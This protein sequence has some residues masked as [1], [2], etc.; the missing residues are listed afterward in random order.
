[1]RIGYDA[2]RYFHN[3]TGLGNYSRTLVNGMMAQYPAHEYSLFDKKAPKHIDLPAQIVSKRNT[4][5]FWRQFGISKDIN[6]K[7]LD[8]YHGLSAELPYSRPKKAKLVVTIHDLI[9]KKFPEYYKTVDRLIYAHKTEN[10][11]RSADVVIATSKQTKADLQN[12]MPDD[13]IPIEV[14]Y[15]DCDPIF[16]AH[17]GESGL[18]KVV[19]KYGLPET[20]ILMVS[21]FEKRKNHLNVLKAILSLPN[22]SIPVVMAGK[23]GDTYDEVQAFIASNKLTSRVTLIEDVPTQ[24]LPKLY[25]CATATIFPSL[26][27]GF[28]IPVLESLVSGTPVITSANSCMEE[29]AGDAALYFNPED[30]ESIA[31]SIK[32][33]EDTMT[34]DGLNLYI[35]KRIEPFSNTNILVQHNSLYMRL[36]SK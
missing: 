24:D 25:S 8:V 17:H 23:K 26:Y 20:Y 15:Q 2:K 27:E 36:C 16:Y 5:L 14:I 11:L 35:P 22:D 29:I 6:N 28:G 32:Q 7:G 18:A 30:P 13:E 9:F 12:M 31:Y 3:R 1:M 10:A 34:L 33:I 21:K 19:K 4:A